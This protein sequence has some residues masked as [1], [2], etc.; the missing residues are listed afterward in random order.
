MD[1]IA[2]HPSGPPSSV[3]QSQ[4]SSATVR[5]VPVTETFI[6]PVP[7][8]RRVFGPVTRTE[9]VW[10]LTFLSLLVVGVI[11][12]QSMLQTPTNT[13]TQAAVG[14]A[15]VS[16]FP[17]NTEIPPD[18][19]FQVWVTADNPVK[20]ATIVVSFDPTVLQLTKDIVL[21]GKLGYQLSFTPLTKA[22]LTGSV[23]IVMTPQTGTEPLPAGTVQ[24][25]SLYFTSVKKNVDTS[26]TVSINESQTRIVDQGSVP[27]SLS[28]TN[29]IVTLK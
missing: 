26:T 11:V 21:V 20:E 19:P 9:T 4:D 1:D 18:K 12:G 6:V 10:K 8:Y 2:Q 24:I 27:F 7:W 15:R 13:L 14:K 29:V 23:E 5:L 25:G 28:T 22:N 16:L 3:G 17:Q